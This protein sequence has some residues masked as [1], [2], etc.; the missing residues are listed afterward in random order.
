M[1]AK[2]PTDCYLLRCRHALVPPLDHQVGQRHIR[3]LT[4]L[5]RKACPLPLSSAARSRSSRRAGSSIASSNSVPIP[6]PHLSWELRTPPS[7]QKCPIPSANTTS[8]GQP[9]LCRDTDSVC[10]G[11][12]GREVVA[13]DLSN[14]CYECGRHAGV[15]LAPCPVC[16]VVHYCSKKCQKHSWSKGHCLECPYL[17]QS[18]NSATKKGETHN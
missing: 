16:R 9:L 18:R 11:S 15:H 6:V 4:T 1:L 8:K 14:F 13:K 17:K 2:V 5:R 10:S 3:Q 7:L 12:T